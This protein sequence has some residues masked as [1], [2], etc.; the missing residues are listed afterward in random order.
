MNLRFM[1]HCLARA[2]K[3][4]LDFNSSNARFIQDLPE[5]D[6]QAFTYNFKKGLKVTL[7]PPKEVVSDGLNID[8]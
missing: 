4:H 5:E 2:V 3:M 8:K 6:L 1:C 7:N